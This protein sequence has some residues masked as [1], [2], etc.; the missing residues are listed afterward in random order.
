MLAIAKDVVGVL[1]DGNVTTC[2]KHVA[3]TGMSDNNA[4]TLDDSGKS[5][6]QG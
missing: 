4:A 6:L 2:L 5:S 1:N 3:E